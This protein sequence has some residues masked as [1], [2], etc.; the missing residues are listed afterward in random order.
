VN[1]SDYAGR[2]GE[3]LDEMRQYSFN[4]DAMLVLKDILYKVW[5]S[6]QGQR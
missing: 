3:M 5:K 1:V 2:L 6:R 4:K